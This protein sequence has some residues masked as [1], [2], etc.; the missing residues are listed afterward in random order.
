MVLSKEG[1]LIS[2]EG[3]NITTEWKWNPNLQG[4]G[5]PPQEPVTIT[6]NSCLSFVFTDR[7][8]I[9]CKF[10]CEGAAREFDLSLKLRRMDTYLDH[11]T[12]SKTGSQRGK[13]VPDIKHTTLVQRHDETNDAM[14]ATRNKLNPKSKDLNHGEVRRVVANLEKGFDDYSEAH[15]KSTVFGSEWKTHALDKTTSEIPQI[16]LTGQETGPLDPAGYGH[17]IYFEDDSKDK[18]TSRA[19]ARLPPMLLKADGTWRG[20]ADLRHAIMHANPLLQRSQVLCDASGRYSE[21]ILVPGGVPTATNPTGMRE[22]GGS[23][24]PVVSASKLDSYLKDVALPHQLVVVACLR[25]DDQ[26][27]RIAEKVVEG[28]HGAVLRGELDGADSDAA[29]ASGGGGGDFNPDNSQFRVVKVAMSE[30]RFMVEQY[31]IRSLPYFLMFSQSKLVYSGAIGGK[32]IRVAPETMPWRVLC[33]E[34]NF[35]D[36][37]AT[38]KILRKQRYHWDLCMNAAQAA[39]HKQR[40]NETAVQSGAASVGYD[41]V[42]LSDELASDDIA[43]IERNFKSMANPSSKRVI[44]CGLAGVKGESG[45]AQV[46]G[47]RWSGKRRGISFDNDVL[48]PPRLASAVDVTV[49]KPLKAI[50]LEDVSEHIHIQSRL[51]GGSP[52]DQQY[53]GLT[54][55]TL[56]T[57]MVAALETAHRGLVADTASE[58]V[59]RATA[60][61]NQLIRTV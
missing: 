18:S 49:V 39:A 31:H 1:G 23:V 12:R 57:Q 8:N 51:A 40:L 43:M 7:F 55:D 16:A 54:K 59:N 44:F 35:A 38:E 11:A 17:S 5:T 52:F 9:A 21:D 36:Q 10:V 6:L 32:A 14:K 29:D 45:A 15:R 50:A 56:I 19:T 2:D 37:I 24:L 28:V 61:I 4:A 48:L 47:A 53:K 30:S 25:E 20:G 3:G 58:R 26:L 13:L 42:L 34:P 60:S 33:V 46:K 22:S 41:L 27:C